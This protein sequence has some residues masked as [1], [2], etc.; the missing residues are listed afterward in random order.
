[1][2]IKK[3]NSK[4]NSLPLSVAP[5]SKWFFVPRLLRGSFETAKV[6]TLATLRDYNFLLK[7]S[8]E[9]G[10]KAML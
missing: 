9:M 3:V 10:S 8:I 6:W 1:M 4:V 5:T 7:P 2:G